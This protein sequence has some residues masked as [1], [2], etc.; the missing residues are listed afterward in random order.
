MLV[1]APR[2]G[3]LATQTLVRSLAAHMG[4]RFVMQLR[5]REGAWS[6]SDKVRLAQLAHR[7]G[8][9]VWVNRD[10]MLAA[11][12]GAEGMH[13][14]LTQSVFAVRSA[15]VHSEVERVRAIVA[16][17][18]A[19][20][21]S[22]VFDVPEKGAACGLGFLQAVVALSPGCQVWAL[23]G[24]NALNTRDCISAGAIGVAMQRGLYEATDLKALLESLA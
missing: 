14:D 3:F 16:R 8:A 7:C 5:D 17:A 18:N 2:Y 15:P 9:R 10:A 6:H 19:L 12:V 23:G 24:I 20:I 1:T 4:A 21:V 22:P 11:E 13:A